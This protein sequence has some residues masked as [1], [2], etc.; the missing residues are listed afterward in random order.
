M[1]RKCCVSRIEAMVSWSL[2]FRC[3]D[4]ISVLLYLVLSCCGAGLQEREPVNLKECWVL[5]STAV[6]SW[7]HLSV[8]LVSLSSSCVNYSC[9]R[10]ASVLETSSGCRA[11]Q[12]YVTWWGWY[13]PTQLSERGGEEFCDEPVRRF[14]VVV[15][16]WLTPCATWVP[17]P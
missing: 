1:C 8:P 6:L 9:P 10:P 16:P 17:W 11:V 12:I 14:E 4:S 7:R 3:E 13:R 2:R 5:F 15:R